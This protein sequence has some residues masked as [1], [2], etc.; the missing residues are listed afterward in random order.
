MFK[1][2]LFHYGIPTYNFLNKTLNNVY[3]SI[4]YTCNNIL[5]GYNAGTL[6]FYENNPNVYMSSFIDTSNK[7]NGVIMWKYDIFTQT[8]YNY[9]CCFKDTKYLPVLTAS[10]ELHDKLIFDLTDFVRN[11][12][13][14]SSNINYPSL[15]H[16]L[17][18]FEYTNGIIFDRNQ[19]YVF[20]YF[21]TN[22]D[23]KTVNLFEYKDIFYK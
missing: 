22:L 14:E 18:A 12:K 9:S 10:V 17:T 21:D 16:I 19:S 13:V 6:Y 11:I 15:N 8:F 1:Q 5:K 7:L 3:E 2:I 23:E 20:K 4:Y